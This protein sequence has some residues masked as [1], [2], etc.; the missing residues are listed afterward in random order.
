MP[1]AHAQFLTFF[2]VYVVARTLHRWT[3]HRKF[4]QVFTIV[5]VLVL[6]LLVC[7][8]R[9]HLGYHSHEQVVVGAIVGTISGLS[10]FVLVTKLAPVLFPRIVAT[11]LAQFFYLRDISPIPD[12][13]VEQ[14]RLCH[15]KTT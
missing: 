14:H 6:A 12:L 2:A 8:S 7:I 11:P 1:S 15:P 3:H 4:E 9:V 10:W 5:G 13:I